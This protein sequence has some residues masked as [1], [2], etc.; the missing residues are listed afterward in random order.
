MFVDDE[1][2]RERPDFAEKVWLADTL[3]IEDFWRWLN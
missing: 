2:K 3:I 1:I